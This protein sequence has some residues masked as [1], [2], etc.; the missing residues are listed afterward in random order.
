MNPVFRI[1]GLVVHP[2][3][4]H[5]TLYRIKNGGVF[6]DELEGVAVSRDDEHL[7]AGIVAHLRESRNHIIRLIVL[8]R[9]C[10]YVH[11]GQCFGQQFRLTIELGWC[12]TSSSFVR[13]VFIGPE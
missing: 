13:R 11:R 1:N 6:R 5:N 8:F 2:C 7:V 9:D 10:D 3:Q 4:V 12:F